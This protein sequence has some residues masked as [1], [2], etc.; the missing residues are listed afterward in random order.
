MLDMYAIL[1]GVSSLLTSISVP[2]GGKLGDRFGRRKMCLLIASARIILFTACA[3]PTSGP[4]FFFLV[5]AARMMGGFMGSFCSAIVSDVTGKEE[6]PYWFGFYTAITGAAFVSGLTISGF[7]ADQFNSFTVFALYAP[8]GILGLVLIALFFPNKP[9]GSTSPIDVRGMTLMTLSFSCILFWG[10]FG[11]KYFP[12]TSLFGLLLLAA[13]ILFLYIF[14]RVEKKTADPMLDLNIFRIKPFILCFSTS[15][16]MAPFTQT[17][18]VAL[19]LFGRETLELSSTI[20]GTLPLPKNIVF[21]FLPPLL[22]VWIAKNH[23]RF[24]FAF[25]CTGF[26]FTVACLYASTWT[27]STPILLIYFCM[28]MA[29]IGS[30]CQGLAI[31]PYAQLIVPAHNMGVATSMTS[32]ANTLGVVLFNVVYNMVYNPRYDAA[33]EMGGGIHLSNAIREI[34]SIMCLFSG[35]CA[36]VIIILTFVL[37]PSAHAKKQQAAAN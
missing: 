34:F 11:G 21:T 14:I 13:G 7:L 20:C 32:F 33:M 5:C 36:A 16:L 37:F 4:V 35:A 28:L 3:L 23:R 1:V 26:F 9:S 18:S 31:T 15:L 6:R 8:F 22:G 17:F 24:R 30:A 29:G 12:R 27:A 25:F 2:I 10:S 19:M